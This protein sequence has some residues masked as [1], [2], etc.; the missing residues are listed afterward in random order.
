MQQGRPLRLLSFR[1]DGALRANAMRVAIEREGGK[2]GNAV[3]YDVG[4]FRVRPFHSLRLISIL[5][6]ST[7]YRATQ[8]HPRFDCESP[9]SSAVKMPLSP[10]MEFATPHPQV[11]QLKG[12]SKSLH[13][14]RKGSLDAL[15]EEPPTSMLIGTAGLVPKLRQSSFR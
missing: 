5:Q 3:Q 13:G 2:R 10:S 12:H 9:P 1:S 4:H 14:R 7:M 11:T 8:R 15:L 6:N